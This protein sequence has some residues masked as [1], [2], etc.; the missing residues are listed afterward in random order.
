M[1]PGKRTAPSGAFRA[2]VAGVLSAAALLLTSYAAAAQSSEPAPPDRAACVAAHTNAQEL[3]RGGKLIEAE[4]ELKIC[5][6][7]GCPGAIISDCG[8]WIADLEQTT[9]SLIFEVRVDGKQVTDFEVQVDGANV[10]DH[11]KAHRVNPGR[12]VV[13]VKV[14]NFEPKE[15]T[16]A[17]PEGQRM[18]LVALSFD[19]PKAETA[20]APV[21][22][23]PQRAPVMDRPTPVLV[24]PLLGVGVAGLGSFA[25]FSILGKSK[26]SDLETEC[27]PSCSDDDLAPM[28]RNYLIGDISAGVGAAALV[29]AGVVY[30][31]RP[32]KPTVDAMSSLRIGPARPGEWHSLALSV[33]RTW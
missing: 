8:Q 30:L 5:A 3:K 6:S 4:S 10:A 1:T 7:A 31:T 27:A 18:R 22:L 29:A 14:P 32:S 24:Y 13:S 19:S 16:V 9:P 11:T 15:E 21:A 28:K 25:V 17:L 26:E 23:P 12:H 33:Q 20:Q 2:P